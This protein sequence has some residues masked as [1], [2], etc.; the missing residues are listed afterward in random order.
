MLW[1]FGAGDRCAAKA[2]YERILG[3]AALGHG[4]GEHWAHS[5]YGWLLYQ[6]GDLQVGY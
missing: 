4:P 1:C 6:D 5:D 3:K 2:Q